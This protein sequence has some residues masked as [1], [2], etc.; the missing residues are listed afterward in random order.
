MKLSITKAW[1]EASAFVRQ[2]AGTL[3]LIAFALMTLPGIILQVIAG[4]YVGT[5]L[6]F[7]ADSPP[8]F[9]PWLA[10]LPII[11]L[12]L[13]PAVLLSVWGHL[14]INLLALRREAVIG[15]A[16]G[17]AARRILPLIGAWLLLLIAFVV[18]IALLFGL[19]FAAIGTGRIGLVVLLFLILWLA[20]IFFA[21]R[22]ILV[23]PVAAAETLGPIGIIRRSWQLTAGHFWRLLGF[24]VLIVIVFAV[25]GAVVGALAGIVVTLAAGGP[26]QPGSVSALIIQLVTGVLQA[27][28]V[29]YF[30]VMIARIYAQLSGNAASVA[31]VF[32]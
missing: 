20:A 6:Q 26:P 19:G 5:S 8:D 30:A 14:T 4:R 15:S 22:L 25:L 2:D 27:V 10:A 13:V 17:H 28:F 1:D 24:F 16:L 31:G 7:T 21:I 29:T 12:M 18:P 3:F 11:L 32:E 9:G 23:T